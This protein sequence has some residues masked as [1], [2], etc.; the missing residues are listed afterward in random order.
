MLGNA[1]SVVDESFE[2][3]GLEHPQFTRPADLNGIGVPEVLRSGDHAKIK[4]WRERA[5]L[6]LTKRYRPDL[7]SKPEST[8]LSELT[9]RLW[10]DDLDHER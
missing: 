7:T 4:Q 3:G 5:A 8:P 9:S 10:D 6:A 1:D 2:I